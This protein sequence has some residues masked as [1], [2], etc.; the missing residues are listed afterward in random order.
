[1]FAFSVCFTVIQLFGNLL[2]WY[3]RDI[4][5]SNNWQLPKWL[6]NK[7]NTIQKNYAVEIVHL[8]ILLKRVF[9]RIYIKIDLYLVKLIEHSIIIEI[10][11]KHGYSKNSQHK[12]FSLRTVFGWLVIQNIARLFYPFLAFFESKF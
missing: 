4:A 6:A 5:F 9:L 7:Q 2:L 10:I 3:K 1:M 8:S 11:N 12:L